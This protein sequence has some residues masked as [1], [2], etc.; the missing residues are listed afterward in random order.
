MII[1]GLEP[2]L[3]LYRVNGTGGKKSCLRL[4]EIPEIPEIPVTSA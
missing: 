2:V 3:F 1:E 4:A